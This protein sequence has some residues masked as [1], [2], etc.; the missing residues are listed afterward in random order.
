VQYRETGGMRHCSSMVHRDRRYEALERYGM[1]RLAVLGAG[2][3]QYTETGGMWYW[4]CMVHR[5]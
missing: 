4:S 5:D 3:V 1:Q 2:A